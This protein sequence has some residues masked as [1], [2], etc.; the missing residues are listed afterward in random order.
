MRYE[1]RKNCEYIVEVEAE[2]ADEAWSK[3]P[4]LAQ[5][6]HSWSGTE[7]EEIEVSQ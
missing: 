2:S 4:D 5:W 1:F 6:E 3:L 7:I